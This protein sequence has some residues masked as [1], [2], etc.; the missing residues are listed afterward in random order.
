MKICVQRFIKEV[1]IEDKEGKETKQGY[2]FG[3][4]LWKV[5]SF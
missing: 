4:V 3:K 2:V 1:L 5:A